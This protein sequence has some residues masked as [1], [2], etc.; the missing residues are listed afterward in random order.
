MTPAIAGLLLAVCAILPGCASFVVL[1]DPLTASEHSDL[2][3]VY[4]SNGELALAA[5]EY[6]RALRREPHRAHTRV[7]LGNVEAAR[8]R[9]HRAE[10]CYRRALRDSTTDTDAMNNLAVVLLRQRRS[11]REARGLAERAVEGG[12]A[13][14]SVYR[15]TLAEILAIPPRR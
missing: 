5:H 10:A 15:A 6:H 13:R 12:G 1:N 3:L 9:W 4:E 14:D 2:G 11:L 7:N 8:G